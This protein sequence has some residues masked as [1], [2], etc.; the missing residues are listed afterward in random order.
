[1][2]DREFKIMFCTQCE[3][4]WFMDDDYEHINPEAAHCENCGVSGNVIKFIMVK[5]KR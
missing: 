1:M 3:D 2:I 4:K 5:S